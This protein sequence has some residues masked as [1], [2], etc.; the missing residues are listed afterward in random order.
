MYHANLLRKYL[1][2]EEKDYVK[3]ATNSELLKAAAGDVR[4]VSEEECSMRRIC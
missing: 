1:E 4:K 3:D 2:K